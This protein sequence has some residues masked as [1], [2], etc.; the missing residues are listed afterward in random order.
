MP[1]NTTMAD[2]QNP[3]IGRNDM[4]INIQQP[5]ALHLGTGKFNVTVESM[6]ESVSMLAHPT[7]RIPWRLRMQ[8]LKPFGVASLF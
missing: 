4:N 2:A 5:R 8:P 3:N 7:R 6:K 1:H